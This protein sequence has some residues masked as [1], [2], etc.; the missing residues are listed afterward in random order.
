MR[1]HLEQVQSALTKR[2]HIAMISKALL[3]IQLADLRGLLGKV[4]EGKTI[5][6][7]QVMPAKTDREVI[8]FLAALSALANTAGGDLLIGMER[9]RPTRSRASTTRRETGS[10][11]SDPEHKSNGRFH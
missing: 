7:K 10:A 11:R 6:Y 2:E 5:E 8:E 4:R 1:R 9:I 3:E